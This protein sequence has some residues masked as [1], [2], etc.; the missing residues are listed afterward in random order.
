MNDI[1][2]GLHLLCTLHVRKATSQIHRHL[3]N[4]RLGVGATFV[5]HNQLSIAQKLRF[6][7]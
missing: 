7:K 5:H 3:S 2:C 4:N 1:D 6:E